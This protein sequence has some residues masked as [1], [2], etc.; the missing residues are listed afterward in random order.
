MP[1]MCP[2]SCRNWCN[3]RLK[4]TDA[5]QDAQCPF[6]VVLK[7]FCRDHRD[8]KHFGSADR[9]AWF[10]PMIRRVH[11]V[12]SPN[13]SRGTSILASLAWTT[14]TSN[15]GL[16]HSIIRAVVFQ[17]R[18]HEDK[19]MVAEILLTLSRTKPY[20][21]VVWT[22]GS[23]AEV[24]QIVQGKRDVIGAFSFSEMDS[25]QDG[26]K[27]LGY[28]RTNQEINAPGEYIYYYSRE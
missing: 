3:R 27:K 18:S 22:S 4:R 17:K 14:S 9:R 6:V 23:T 16:I 19:L 21:L 24:Y 1:R 15:Q 11:A 13:E 10:V 2:I 20:A 5:L 8:H 12:G 26:L 28:R 7:V 25:L